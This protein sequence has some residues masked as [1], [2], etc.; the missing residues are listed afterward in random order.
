MKRIFFLLTAG[1][2][3]TMHL[4]AQNP[5]GQEFTDRMNHI[6]QYV[7]KSRISTGL[8]S[9]YGLQFVE[10]KYFDGIPADSNYVSMD[11]WRMLYSGMFTSR[12]NNNASLTDPETVF[13]LIDSAAHPTAVPVAMMHYE[14]NALNEDALTLGLLQI[15]ND[16]QLQ[17]VPGGTSPYLTRQL[18]AAAP[19]ELYF[20]LSAEPKNI[21][22]IACKYQNI[23]YN[24]A[25]YKFLKF[26][27]I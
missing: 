24:F 2:T 9:D 8:L 4:T 13:A 17:D 26:E 23:F 14:Y 18:F 10:P 7:D 15:V 16:D 6:F 5:A 21:F 19:K 3:M 1:I 20:N 27:W 22:E 12:I 25:K 11:T